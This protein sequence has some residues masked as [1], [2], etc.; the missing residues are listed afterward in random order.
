MSINALASAFAGTYPGPTTLSRND[1]GTIVTDADVT[2]L[3]PF[4]FGY[5]VDFAFGHG[6]YVDPLSGADFT[7]TV[8]P[9]TGSGNN[10]AEI[11]VVLIHSA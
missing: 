5:G 10:E 9:Y 4:W 8:A 6:S 11:G 2:A 3:G 7:S 1:S